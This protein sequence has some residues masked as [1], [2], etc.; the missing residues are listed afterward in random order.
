MDLTV[1]VSSTSKDLE[2]YRAVAR[3]EILLM[4]WKPK[5]M[6]FF[7]AIPNATMQAVKD[8]LAGCQLMVLIV[9]FRQGW[10]P[11]PEQGGNG[12][13]SV[14]AL[15]LQFARER[16]IPVLA[17]LASE[18][19]WPGSRYEGDDAKRKWVEKFRAE[20]NLPAAFFG[21]EAPTTKES[22]RLPDFRGKLRKS[23]LDFLATQ[24]KKQVGQA[25]PAPGHGPAQ[26]PDGAISALRSGRCI[27][28]L[29]CGLYGD[30]A[31]STKELI[32]ALSRPD[33]TEPSLATAAEYSSALTRADFL[34]NLD[35]IIERQMSRAP[36]PRVHELLQ[37]HR[38]RLIVSTTC[39]LSLEKHL[40]KESH[41][42]VIVCHVVR[43]IHAEHDG[44]IAVFHGTE[45][46][47]PRLFTADKVDLGDVKHHYVV[48]KPQGSPLLHRKMDPEA[49]LDTV[50]LTEADHLALFGRLENQCTGI[51]TAFSRYFQQ[52]PFI[53]LGYP[54][55]LWH[56][57]L[58][59]HVFRAIGVPQSGAG[60]LNHVGV[61]M[62]TTPMEAVAWERLG[63]EVVRMDAN[64]LADKALEAEAAVT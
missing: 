42:V 5:M 24:L 40:E 35:D 44:K 61:R 34:A 16:E 37:R 64:D 21:Y 15:E 13:D 2:D 12:I 3:N 20:L 4:G 56:Y 28:F 8:E 45:D 52:Y 50:V 14:T 55:D 30:G 29:G 22:E 27:P 26:R 60:R 19:T 62:P 31:L 58:I 11:T 53:F 41:K 63:I 7:G 1:F 57:R 46:G 9:A 48:Y 54:M 43:S 17:L 39:D 51:P 47:A 33:V 32:K 49:V 36:A 25:G 18:E 59:V 10:V 23:L 6:E 38:P